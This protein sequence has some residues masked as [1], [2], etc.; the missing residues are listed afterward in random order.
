LN[1]RLA[2]VLAIVLIGL[3][4]DQG[5]KRLA[6]ERLRAGPV[7][8]IPGIAQLRAIEN[9]GAIL[10]L[11]SSLAAG[12]R[13]W[14]FMVA[15]TA[16]LVAL[17]GYAI[18]GK[19]ARQEEVW[20]LSLVVAGGASNVLDRAAHGFVRDYAL[21][22]RP[23]WPT[24]AFNL[25]DVF[26]VA[27][28]VVLLVGAWRAARAPARAA[29]ALLLVAS[30]AGIAG[31]AEPRPFPIRMVKLNG[32]ASDAKTAEHVAFS[33]S[34]GFNA[35]WVYSHE[36]GSWVDRGKLDPAFVH[37]A[38]EAEA[39]GI[40]I[41]VSI[42]PVADS[43]GRFVFAD[44]DGENRIV[45]FIRKLH[46]QAGVNRVVLSFDDQPV[47]LTEFRDIVRYGV[48]AAPAHL[49]LVRRVARRLPH[50]VSLWFCGAAYCDGH[51][52]DGHGAYAAPFLAG[53]A[54]L[55]PSVGIVWT[56]TEVRSPSITAADLRAT[57]ARLGGRPLLLYDNFPVNDD[58]G[59]ALALILG[60]LRHRD[61]AIRDVVDAYLACPMTELGGSRL[62]L[63][64]IATFLRDPE[65]YD[66]DRTLAEA[67]DRFSGGDPAVRRAL[68]TQVIEWGGWIGGR[69]YWP[70]DLLNAFDA[71]R[72]LD[73]PAFVD[74]FTW[75]ADRYPA[76][77]G[78][79]AGVPDRA[80]RD[81]LLMVMARRLAVAR[82]MPLT[83]EYL[84]RVRAGRADA[85]DVLA[86]I[87]QQRRDL[88]ASPD[89]REAL[90]VFLR[91]ASVPIS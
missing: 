49:D 41:W 32:R 66:P 81:D 12:S 17:A 70:R 1:R 3:V 30:S 51:L 26:V 67:L 46:K 71:G 47:E 79:L 7:P 72:R 8:V 18:R 36:A 62:P 63:F 64:T 15:E 9:R 23:G 86:Q 61:P 35:L 75:T 4:V 90:D 13:T 31:A 91:A 89:A 48:S 21:I 56:G 57:R 53:L 59:D 42:S 83:V 88:A 34:L 78:A 52:G 40:G 28:A 58:F 29:A 10:G 76:R 60:A 25:A 54:K 22:G 85:A 38:R 20:A 80:F 50:G 37:L 84:A 68:D 19:A 6:F 33:R 24:A 65:G 73:D 55:P 39:D 5:L 82:A 74:S 2:L 43:R 44:P 16:L 87:E 14:M 45:K 27:G 69:N 77:M 11:G